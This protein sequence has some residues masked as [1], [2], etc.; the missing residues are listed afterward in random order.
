MIIVYP[1]SSF[2]L[3]KFSRINST[4]IIKFILLLKLKLKYGKNMTLLCGEI[5]YVKMLT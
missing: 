1:E 5:R 4:I 2:F 3:R